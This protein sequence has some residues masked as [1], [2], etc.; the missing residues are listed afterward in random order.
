MLTIPALRSTFLPCKSPDF[1]ISSPG[2]TVENTLLSF[3]A[4]EIFLEDTC[5]LFVF[6][7]GP[8]AGDVS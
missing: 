5:N 4:S 8:Q 3:C 6:Q 1:C 2:D 7:P